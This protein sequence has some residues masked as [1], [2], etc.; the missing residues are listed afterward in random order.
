MHGN[1]RDKWIPYIA[2]L[3]PAL[4]FGLDFLL[5]ELYGYK[6]GYEMLMIN[7]ALTFAGFIWS[8][9]VETGKRASVGILIFGRYKYKKPGNKSRNIHFRFYLENLNRYLL[10][11]VRSYKISPHG[12]GG[13]NKCS[14]SLVY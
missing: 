4:C 8:L 9:W 5:R 12:I 2:L 10:F 13:P 7:G 14:P 11:Y 1:P 3:S 6:L